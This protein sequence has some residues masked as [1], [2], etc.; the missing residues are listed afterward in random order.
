MLGPGLAALAAAAVAA[1]WEDIV[2]SCLDVDTGR[3]GAGGSADGAEGVRKL[4]EH[5][6]G[7]IHELRHV[8]L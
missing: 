5:T 1:C 6:R 8:S 7:A 4:S 2:V 3:S